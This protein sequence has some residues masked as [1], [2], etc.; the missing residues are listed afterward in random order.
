M[1]SNDLLIEQSLFFQSGKD[2]SI[3]FAL[4]FSERIARAFVLRLTGG[5]ANMTAA[6]GIGMA[7]LT[8]ALAGRG[9]R[10]AALPRFAGFAMFGG[11]RMVSIHDPRQVIPGITEIFPSIAAECPGT[12]ML[13]IVPGF[14]QILRSRQPGL[15]REM[16]LS[17]EP[18]KNHITIVH[19]HLDSVL[20]LQPPADIDESKIWDEEF[21]E[22]Y[23]YIR[24]LHERKW[25]S[26]LVVYNGGGATKREV[27]LWAEWSLREPG[28]WPVLLVR[29]SGRTADEFAANEAFLAAHPDVHVAANSVEAINDKLYELGA[30]VDRTEDANPDNRPSVL[31]FAPQTRP[32][33][34]SGTDAAA[35]STELK[36]HSSAS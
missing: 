16:I 27:E 31:P 7:N 28:R 8:N 30:V 25:Q 11:T 4:T 6:D 20:F 22:C 23:K 36:R 12:V 3:D 26:L 29:E 24:T 2:R 14:R 13:G 5:C 10:G 17:V 32:D 18:A 1:D 33:G 35:D 19:P 15:E 34:Q 9:K 21:K